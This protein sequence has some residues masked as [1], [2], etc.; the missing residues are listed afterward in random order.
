MKAVA[1]TRYLPIADP[2]S[3]V[4]VT[5]PDP[6]PAGHDILVKVEA[7][8]VNPVDTKQRAPNPKVETAPRVLGYDAAGT[9]AAV[10]PEVTLF[11]AR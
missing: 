9:V 11:K 4:D 7:V 10:G 2:E 8:S 5:L 1:L 6:K 3:L